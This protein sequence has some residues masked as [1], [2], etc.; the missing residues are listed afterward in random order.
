ML[1]ARQ[2]Y[3]RTIAIILFFGAGG[4]PVQAA[5]RIQVELT[6]AT[7]GGNQSG[8]YSGTLEVEDG[9]FDGNLSGGIGNAQ[10]S[11][12][13]EEGQVE[14]YGTLKPDPNWKLRR[15]KV[16]IPLIDGRASSKFQTGGGILRAGGAGGEFDVELTLLT[17]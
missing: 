13:I 12:E 16:S 7:E 14:V 5:E 2:T 17:D 10:L 4:L 6:W 3:V 9:E 11:G 1:R 8:K 15:F